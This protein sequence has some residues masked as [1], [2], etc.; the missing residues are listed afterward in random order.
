MA[1]VLLGAIHRP[2]PLIVYTAPAGERPAGA[3]A[4]HPTDA[5]LPSGRIAAP[6][7][8]SVFVG[9][10]P[11]GMALS[12]DGRFAIVSNDSQRTGGLAI[13]NQQ[14][15]PVIGYSLAVVNTKTMA[16]ASVYRGSAS[17]FMGVAAVADPS[18]PSRTI[19]L[20]SDAGA[21]VVLVFDLDAS[22]QL[23]LEPQS[24]A[25]PATGLQRPF[26]AGIA[27]DPNGRLA[28]VADNFGNTVSVIDI[29]SR[30]VL[31]TIPVGD[32]PFDVAAAGGH[33]LASGSGLANYGPL[34]SPAPEPAFAAPAFDPQRASSLS[35]IAL[36]QGGSDVAGDPGTVQMEPAPDGTEL[37]GGVAPGAIAINRDG[38]VAYV[39]L[40]NVDRV[41]VVRL[42]GEPRVVRGLDLRLYPD[43]PFG[44]QPSAEALSPDGK[45][46]YVALAGLNAVA[47]LDARSPKRYRYGLIPTGWYPSA[48]ALSR[49]G[50]TLFVL[51]A[52]GVDGWGMLQRIDLKHTS[53]VKA[54]LA[55]L[56]YNRT[57]KVAK[58]DPVIPPLRSDK[59]STA[60]DHVIYIAV[61]TQPYDAMLGDL[62]DASGT[63]H[64][65]GSPALCV[66]PQDVTPNLHALA[67]SYALA[68]NFYAPDLNLDVARQFGMAADAP[69]YTQLTANVSAMRLPF[70]GTADPEN[71]VRTGYL[72]NAFSRAGLTFRDYGGLL[73]LSGYRDGR[74]GL[75]VPALAVLGGNVDLDYAG[76]N[77]RISDARRAQEFERDMQRFV[78]ADA[79]PAYTYVWLPSGPSAAAVG[80]ADRALGSIVDFVSH[81]PHWSSTAI[82]IVPE[83]VSGG[84]DHVNEM[85]SYAVVVSP[86]AR[87]GYVGKA[88]LSVP[89][90]VKTEEE[91][92]GLPPLTLNDLLAS[93]M[94]DFFTDTPDP[95]AYQALR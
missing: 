37:V 8:R 88:N 48:L 17:F 49:N 78:Q 26:P 32:F 90:I 71:Y 93:D 38:R 33:V 7:G 73:R 94:A 80:D 45:R 53:L 70:D 57:P 50:R 51:D 25:L 31:H 69:L 52:K 68:D 29:G 34:A 16:L 43:A 30:R 12:P 14:P 21:G 83:G 1:A 39:A 92:F 20:A 46:L 42:E 54:T 4:V 56:R 2:A 82:F 72:F 66:Y 62:K 19:V 23:T 84:P 61:G 74:Y 10:N 86:L 36:A 13:P 63:P 87:R 11:L 95:Q 76:P 6:S 75:N 22:G 79:V 28:F 67:L 89:S 60:I 91:I 41:A 40:G 59:R 55:A 77:P 81:T 58:F 65:N 64:G 5:I 35:V 9:T 85:R 18:D 47:V 3:N 15:P 44:A 24:I 27:V